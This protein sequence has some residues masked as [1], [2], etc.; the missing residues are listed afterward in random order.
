LNDVKP[1]PPD[2]DKSARRWVS[3]LIA[4]SAGSLIEEPGKDECDEG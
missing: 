4:G 2:V 3:P 1:P